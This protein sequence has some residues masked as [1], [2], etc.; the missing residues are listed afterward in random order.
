MALGATTGGVMRLV[1]R[2]GG[3][4]LALGGALGLALGVGLSQLLR[5]LMFGVKPGDPVVM[6]GVVAVLGGTGIAA[7]LVPALRASRV[8]PIGALRAE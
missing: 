3:A 2:Q 6:L 8:D 1:L 5:G 7:C 4:Q